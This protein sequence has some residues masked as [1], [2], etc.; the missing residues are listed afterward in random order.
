MST[1]I[2]QTLCVPIRINSGNNANSLVY[3]CPI[4]LLGNRNQVSFSFNYDNPVK[5]QANVTFPT[6]YNGIDSF[7]RNNFYSIIRQNYPFLPDS[8]SASMGVSFAPNGNYNSASSLNN[9]FYMMILNI[10]SAV[11]TDFDVNFNNLVN[12]ITGLSNLFNTA[13]NTQNLALQAIT[14]ALNN[15][16]INIG[17]VDISGVDDIVTQLQ[18]LYTINASQ[19]ANLSQ[20]SHLSNIVSAIT[21]KDNQSDIRDELRYI[22][23]QSVNNDTY[24][25]VNGVYNLSIFKNYNVANALN[26][27]DTLSR[28][29]F[30]KRIA[31]ISDK[32]SAVN[33]SVSNNT[34]TEQNNK[35]IYNLY[36]LFRSFVSTDKSISNIDLAEI[37]DTSFFKSISDK[38]QD[39][40]TK[41]ENNLP[42]STIVYNDIVAGNPNE[43][44]RYIS[45]IEKIGFS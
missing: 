41:L 29:L 24:R 37:V 4:I 33:D 5:S 10:T 23:T 21:N 14:T 45:E 16:Q 36:K 40:E 43:T 13:F 32:L 34:S 8:I 7:V 30:Y 42:F 28:S 38:L 39:I 27:I 11:D 9:S 19:N 18:N 44:Y 1:N 31:N 15:L 3:T 22:F 2:V 12:S 25:L 20:L 35:L 6:N 26:S 17:D